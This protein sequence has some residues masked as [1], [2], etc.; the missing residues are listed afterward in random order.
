MVFRTFTQTW[1]L[2]TEQ[3]CPSLI[4]IH[5]PIGGD[6]WRF[7]YPFFEA[8]KKF[9]YVG[10]DV[11]IVNAARLPVDPEQLGKI[12]GQNY[13]DPRDTLNPMMFKGC[14]GE[15]L[16]DVLNSMYAGLTTDVFKDDGID[17]EVMQ[18]TL[19]EF[20]YTALGDD[21]WRKSPIQKT[22]RI[23]GLHP[24]VYQMATQHQIAPSNNMAAS[25]Y[26]ENAA[27]Y[28]ASNLNSN[29]YQTGFMGKTSSDVARSYM[30]TP[31]KIFDPSTGST[32]NR[33]LGTLFTNKTS[34]LGWL[35]TLQIVGNKSTG[36]FAPAQVTQL[37]KIFMGIL[38]LPPAYL[39]RQYL[40][41]IITHKFKFSGYRT[42]TTGGAYPDWNAYVSH[43]YANRITGNVPSEGDGS[44]SA[45]GVLGA[46]PLYESAEPSEPDPTDYDA[47]EEVDND[48]YD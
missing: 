6:A 19:S 26:I 20:Y 42:I 37:P 46:E 33:M 14:H 9:K 4:G 39:T 7:L 21:A 5:T 12:D 10:C 41:I 36:P 44:K 2:N 35:D 17:K 11:T 31:S 45:D 30:N 8:Y 28:D 47:V 1:D 29:S 15:H 16:G 3:D 22:L 13:V 27:S 48:E 23:R 34:R 32:V 24:I 18:S 43:G 25:D 38:M 40:R